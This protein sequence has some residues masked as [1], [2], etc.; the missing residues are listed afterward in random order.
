MAAK[1]DVCKQACMPATDGKDAQGGRQLQRKDRATCNLR[2]LGR[3]VLQTQSPRLTDHLRHVRRD[4]HC[5]AQAGRA[6]DAARGERGDT[7]R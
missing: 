3:R 6:A 5:W 4:E 7:Q 2:V 1:R